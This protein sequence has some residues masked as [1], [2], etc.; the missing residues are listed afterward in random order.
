VSPYLL[1]IV[2]ALA[3]AVGLTR[4]P[5]TRPARSPSAPKTPV[6]HVPAEIRR[7]FIGPASAGAASFMMVSWVFALSPSFLHEAL[8]IQLTRPLVAGIF[9][10]LVVFTSGV[11]QLVFRRHLSQPATTLGL[12]LV[13]AGMASM[14]F[15]AVS[16]SLAVA[17]IGAVVAGAGA[18]ITQMN[19]MAAVQR[20]APV[21]TRSSV[22]SAYV[23]LC[24]VALSVPVIVAGEAA[25]PFGLVTV[26]RW[27]AVALAAAI[28]VALLLSRPRP[29]QRPSE[30]LTSDAEDA[31]EILAA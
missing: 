16:S 5:E 24:Y 27:F 8:G 23:L 14:T 22:V 2:V 3:L 28:G 31:I 19:A 4:I 15:S 26:T 18:G 9:A 25:E 7:E 29:A 12:S 21:R 11:S 10:A 20:I 1:D 6:I 13:A 30:D 17:V